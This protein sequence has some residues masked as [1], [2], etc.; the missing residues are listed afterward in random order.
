M[1]SGEATLQYGHNIKHETSYNVQKAKNNMRK[2]QNQIPLGEIR[3]I[4]KTYFVPKS[5]KQCPHSR[6]IRTRFDAAR[7]HAGIR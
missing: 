6:G 5:R 7:R 3:V 4:L 1:F 2:Q